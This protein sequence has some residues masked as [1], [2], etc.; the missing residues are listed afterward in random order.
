MGPAWSK[1]DKISDAA[2]SRIGTVIV[3][4]GVKR[5]GS[6]PSRMVWAKRIGCSEVG[7][8]VVLQGVLVLVLVLPVVLEAIMRLWLSS[9]RRTA[10]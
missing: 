2:I 4:M 1:T 3:L 6:E 5:S 10:I 9:K 7:G 8:M